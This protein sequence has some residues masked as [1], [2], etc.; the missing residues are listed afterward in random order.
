MIDESL[1]I[2]VKCPNDSKVSQKLY[3]TEKHTNMEFRKRNV[4]GRLF[5]CLFGKVAN[6]SD[7]LSALGMVEVGLTCKLS[8]SVETVEQYLASSGIVE[9]TTMIETSAADILLWRDRF[10]RNLRDYAFN[11]QNLQSCGIVHR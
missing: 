1:D 8:G 4:R 9:M 7:T 10:R 11:I 5:L 2:V 3:T 6:L